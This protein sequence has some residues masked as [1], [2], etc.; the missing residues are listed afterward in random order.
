MDQVEPSL[1]PPGARIVAEIA[2]LERRAGT[3]PLA[4][5]AFDEV[6]GGCKF[7]GAHPAWDS[8]PSIR[9]PWSPLDCIHLAAS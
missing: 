8:D 1:S 4:L 7:V 3:L 9:W 6:F 2:A 5:R